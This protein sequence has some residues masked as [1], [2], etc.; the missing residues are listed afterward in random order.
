[1]RRNKQEEEQE[2]E[3]AFG[4]EC[5]I[6]GFRCSCVPPGPAGGTLEGTELDISMPARPHL[7]SAGHL[8]LAQAVGA[9][10]FSFSSPTVINLLGLRPNG[11]KSLCSPAPMASG[12]NLQALSFQLG[13]WTAQVFA[14]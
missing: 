6:V 3:K 5:P 10:V 4:D 8:G 13:Y 7:V 2:E 12:L 9:E 1:M 14:L 11:I